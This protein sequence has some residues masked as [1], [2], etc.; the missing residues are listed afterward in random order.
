MSSKSFNPTYSSLQGIS[1]RPYAGERDLPS[2]INLVQT[3]LSEP[4][5]VYTYRYFLQG[6]YAPFRGAVHLSLR[7]QPLLTRLHRPSLSF[8][9]SLDPFLF[10]IRQSRRNENV[11]S[12]IQ[13]LPCPDPF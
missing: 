13:T 11:P 5:V 4:Y 2:I 10:A 3:E 9:V 12:L 8:L 6:W 7:Y 1:Y